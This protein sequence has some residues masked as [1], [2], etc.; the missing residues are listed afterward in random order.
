L[1]TLR[2]T[3]NPPGGNAPKIS[4]FKALY[5]E[6]KHFLTFENKN[7][8]K[9]KNIHD[10]AIPRTSDLSNEIVRRTLKPHEAIHLMVLLVLVSVKYSI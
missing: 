6:G 5:R 4:K 2:G 1:A 10:P 9:M 8:H 3:K 7:V